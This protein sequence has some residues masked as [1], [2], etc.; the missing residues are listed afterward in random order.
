MF[1]GGRT[2][3]S[4]A[5]VGS[6]SQKAETLT[7]GMTPGATTP[8][9]QVKNAYSTLEEWQA[10]LNKAAGEENFAEVAAA[11]RKWEASG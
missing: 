4:S 10:A 11:F 8:A 2:P 5:T 3:T 1:F 9:H 7:A 6:T